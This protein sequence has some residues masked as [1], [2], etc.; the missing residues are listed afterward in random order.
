MKRINLFSPI[1]TL[2]P[3]FPTQL[4]R[5]ANVELTILPNHAN[6]YRGA[7][8]FARKVLGNLAL[9]FPLKLIFTRWRNDASFS[10]R[11][12]HEQTLRDN[13]K[14][15]HLH[16]VSQNY[17]IKYNCNVINSK[18]IFSIT[19]VERDPVIIALSI[20]QLPYV[21]IKFRFVIFY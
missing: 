7:I 10:S 5:T 16:R 20:F 6:I 21:I 3:T 12:T 9:T 11:A 15:Y 17:R 4:V 1:S 8:A 14:Y 19:N 18:I 2:V 13:Y